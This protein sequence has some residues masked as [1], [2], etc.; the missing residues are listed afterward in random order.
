MAPTKAITPIEH[1]QPLEA[2]SASV[3]A[4][5]TTQLEAN[6]RLLREVVELA[7]IGR[8]L[9]DAAASLK[10]DVVVGD[11][12]YWNGSNDQYEKALAATEND[13]ISNSLVATASSDA[14][15]M[16]LSKTNATLGCIAIGGMHDLSD[17]ALT[18]A[19]GSTTPETG[20]YY[21]SAVTAGAVTLQRP[22]VSVAVAVVCSSG[23][24]LIDPQ[25]RDFL[26]DHI[27]QQ[28]ELTAKPA[29]DHSPPA[30]GGRHAIT[31]PDSAR[32]G[33]LPALDASFGGKAPEGAAFGY[34]LAA[35]PQLSQVWPPIP[36]SNA[37]LEVQ[38]SSA[39]SEV[40]AL[41]ADAT[42]NFPSVAV[43]GSE[44]LTVTVP[45]ARSGDPVSLTP[46]GGPALDG[47]IQAWVTADDT[48][49]VRY[50]NPTAAP[51]N[52]DEQLYHIQ[53]M[54]NP[55][56]VDSVSLSF[57]GLERVP[58]EFVVF[59][60]NG[61]WWMTNCYNEVP[62]PTNFDNTGSSSS[63]S[64]SSMS[65]SSSSS[66]AGLAECPVPQPMRLI[67]SFVKMTFATDKTVVTS[68]Q[69]AVGSPIVF[70][71]CDGEPATTGDLK[72][73]LDLTLSED[74]DEVLGGNV[75]KSIDNSLVV[76]KGFVIE[77]LLA[78]SSKVSLTGTRTRLSDPA[79][80]TSP[81]LYQGVVTVDVVVTPT[82]TELDAQLT[83]LADA[84][85]RFLFDGIPSIGFP[86]SSASAIRMKFKI[87]PVGL[88]ASPK[89]KI[90][91]VLFGRTTGTL[92]TLIMSQRVIARPSPT[93]ILTTTD[94]PMTF[95]AAVS[96]T[97]DLAIEVDS[98]Q[99]D[100]VAGDTVYVNLSRGAADGYA[101]EVGIIRVGGIIVPG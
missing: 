35:E 66:S 49:T 86:I 60:A 46:L 93:A 34:N 55:D 63:S 75:V 18:N 23:Q 98:S 64:I 42:L 97:A 30:V 90:R 70:L 89:L 58:S 56:G 9:I 57:N 44:E 80:P 19:F 74:P 21:L 4:R 88:P 11:I 96:V 78:G 52:P 5:P 79:D 27:H 82:E 71:N 10:S 38:H 17:E 81:L 68:L 28:F 94:T 40:K 13:P 41:R 6:L 95:A 14:I 31:S 62:W 69:P 37:L 72:A 3:A 12:V 7:N 22:P 99:F 87:P 33:W 53:V 85:E 50:T 76:G 61:I 39:F 8:G 54:P 15:G 47:V 67:L 77:G 101:A 2:V 84:R 51:I 25:M 59:D 32:K 36:V 26:E 91:V 1:V 43:D 100:I 16:V 45:G 20:R 73:G 24:I 48:V 65:V 92:P 83:R 29:G